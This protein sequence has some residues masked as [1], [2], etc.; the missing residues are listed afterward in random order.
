MSWLLDTNAWIQ[1]LKNPGGVIERKLHALSPSDIQLC[2]VVKAE[3][4]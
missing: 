2:S 3:L 1:H 4:W